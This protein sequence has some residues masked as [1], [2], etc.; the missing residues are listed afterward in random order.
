MSV[1]Y[2]N[3]NMILRTS[4]EYFSL[5]HE[6]YTQWSFYALRGSASFFSL[7]LHTLKGSRGTLPF[8]ANTRYYCAYGEARI[9]A[10]A[11][12]TGFISRAPPLKILSTHGNPANIE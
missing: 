9:Q 3:Y 12:D 1:C 4:P 6:T 2:H 8:H 11:V 10:S 5:P 7:C